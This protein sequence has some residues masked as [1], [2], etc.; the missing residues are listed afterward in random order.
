LKYLIFILSFFF[1]TSYSL[2]AQEEEIT[3][4]EDNLVL[5]FLHNGSIIQG[6]LLENGEEIVLNVE[7]QN[8]NIPYSLVRK[9]EAYRKGIKRFKKGNKVRLNGTK[10]A[11]LPEVGGF[12]HSTQAGI[13]IGSSNWDPFSTSIRI[14]NGYQWKPNWA[15]GL[16]IGLDKYNNR[17]ISP[18]FVEVKGDLLPTKGVS[19]LAFGGLG[20]GLLVNKQSSSE[21]FQENAG[22]Y[23]ETGIGLRATLGQNTSFVVSAGQQSQ[24][25]KTR[26]YWPENEWGSDSWEEVTHQAFRRIFVRIGLIF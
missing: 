21:N 14:M 8:M 9:I 18:V 22:L 11:H 5:V 25:Y 12:Y 16:G 2:I 10:I 1:L 13:I 24:A 15:F 4:L 3:T 20:R 19:P 17:L 6:V 7:G 23:W 26:W